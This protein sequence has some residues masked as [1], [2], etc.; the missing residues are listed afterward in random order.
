MKIKTWKWVHFLCAQVRLPDAC[1]NIIPQNPL[2]VY[3]KFSTAFERWLFAE[4]IP[5]NQLN[6]PKVFATIGQI[7]P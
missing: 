3:Q 5:R 7:I 2:F 6:I 4:E 1:G